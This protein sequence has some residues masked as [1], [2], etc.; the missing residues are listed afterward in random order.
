VIELLRDQGATVLEATLRYANFV[1]AGEIFSIGN[2]AKVTPVIRINDRQLTPGAF[3]RA[4]GALACRQK[5]L[6]R[7]S[8]N[9][10]PAG[11]RCRR[12]RGGSVGTRGGVTVRR[13]PVRC[14]TDRQAGGTVDP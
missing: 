5:S 14:P 1:A 11:A 2:L 8:S 10:I 3:L 4:C 13:S 12:R 7:L 6:S 9:D